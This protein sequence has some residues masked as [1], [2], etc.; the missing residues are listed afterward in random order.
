MYNNAIR[1]NMSL[2]FPVSAIMG[3]VSLCAC[4]HCY[5]RGDG[6]VAGWIEM[7]GGDL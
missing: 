1:A 5:R 4:G 6:G 2:H 7:G 3:T